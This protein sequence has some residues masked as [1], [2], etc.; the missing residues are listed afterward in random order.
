MNADAQ[1]EYLNPLRTHIT[2][3]WLRSRHSSSSSERYL[4]TSTEK[5]R[6]AEVERLFNTFDDD[7][8]GYMDV[9]EITNL[10]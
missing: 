4:Y 5:E 7:R 8:S 3:N 1:R 10:F 6:C 2:R 9:R